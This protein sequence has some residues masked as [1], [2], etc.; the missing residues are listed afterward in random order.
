MPDS[1]IL[2][3]SFELMG[4]GPPSAIAACAGVVFRLAPGFDLSSPAPTTD[5]VASLVLDGEIPAGR[6]S[7]NRTISLPIAVIAPWTGSQ[8]AQRSLLIAG[9][10]VLMR[11]VNQDTFTLTWVREGSS[12]PLIFDCYRAGPAQVTYATLH[13][14]QLVAQVVLTFPAA[15]YGRSDTPVSVSFISP[16]AGLPA[17]PS[18]VTVD[19]FTTVSGTQ[20]AASAAGPTGSSAFWNPAAGPANN[21][22]G[23][24]MT[25][26]Y[27]S[28]GLSLNL[29]QGWDVTNQGNPPVTTGYFVLTEA[30]AATVNVADQFQVW[31]TAGTAL[32]YP[33]I[34]NVTSISPVT[35]G[36]QNIFFT[37]PAPAVIAYQDMLVQTGPPGL[38]AVTFLAGFGSS[39]FF[40]TWARAG[41]AVHFR[42]TLTDVYGST[43]AYS[44]IYPLIYGSSNSALPKWSKI[45]IPVTNAAGFDF[46]NVTGYELQVSNRGNSHLEYAAL[47]LD[48]MTAVPPATTV[49]SPQRGAVY[50]L[51]GMTGS[52]RTAP[53]FQFQLQ[54]PGGG[55]Q[56]ALQSFTQ[57]GTQYWTCPYGVTSVSV[58]AIAGGAGSAAFGIHGG[59]GGGGGGSATDASVAVTPGNTYPVTV[60][61]GGTIGHDGGS[62][63]FAGDTA[64][65]ATAGGVTGAGTAGG[66]GGAAG[67]GGYAGGDGGAG[68]SSG[69]GGG[70]GGGGSAGSGGTGSNGGNASGASG[71]A[72]AAAV[73][74]GG[75]GGKGGTYDVCNGFSP[76]RGYGGGAGGSPG[77]AFGRAGGGMS[78]I[79]QLTYLT[80]PSFQT[81]IAH[82]PGYDQ[83][84]NFMPFVSL[85]PGDPVDGS[86]TYTMPPAVSG[87]NA[88]FGGTYSVV[89][90][91]SA[92][93]TPTAPR[94]ITVTVTEWDQPFGNSYTQEV[95]W[96]LTPDSLIPSGTPFAVLG[97]LTIPL[98]ELPPENLNAFY[99]VSVTDS[100]LDD[101]FLEV[102][103]LDTQGSTVMLMAPYGMQNAWI[104]APTGLRDT[105]LILGS[106]LDRSTAVSILSGA[107][108]I[109][110]GPLTVDPGG[111][112]GFLVYS[113]EGAPSAQ[114]I[115]TPRWIL[116]RLS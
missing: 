78:G 55:Y 23:K 104:D 109:S 45:R 69:T 36:Y 1:L 11:A 101:T 7:S 95:T 42:L 79:V 41:G 37:P 57:P 12:L 107:Q 61:H 67:S 9:R 73:S 94:T 16:L 47:Y 6:R 26:V 32:I 8:D 35:A 74:G 31:N 19:D 90:V 72:A 50:D 110:G 91:S 64:Y 116:D 56:S 18:P 77:G 27:S 62:S 106:T 59:G 14:R 93:D 66:S 38:N 46:Q 44:K 76:T 22:S 81:L 68:V 10:E 108:A 83:D 40:H 82:R 4:G 21:P 30:D 60:G 33:A 2:A 84:D 86:V 13:E 51:A 24:G 3:D 102:L 85:N 43:A 103:F 114:M 39:E 34:F 112:Q 113:V 58:Y 100:N 17:P 88:R 49:A 71:G 20:W 99:T 5:F 15:P 63:V 87:L 80:P 28:T 75:K 29:A 89:A 97:N 54:L 96:T 115:Y 25:A 98:A 48:T 70:G 92:W 105:G 65:I 53:S 52:A 111:N